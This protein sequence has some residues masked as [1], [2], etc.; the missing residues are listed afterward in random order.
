VQLAEAG[1]KLE[2]I[3]EA[4]HSMF[5]DNPP[6]FYAVVAAFVDKVLSP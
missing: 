4:G 2:W 3:P 1:V 6:A 5:R